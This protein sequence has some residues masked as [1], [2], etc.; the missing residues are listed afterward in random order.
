MKDDQ[1][2]VSRVLGGDMKAFQ[3]LMRENQRLVT[4]MVSRLVKQ[5]GEVEELCQDIFLK[6]YDKLGEFRFQSKL[7]TWIGTIAYREAINHLR[8]NKIK[9]ADLPNDD[10]LLKKL[11]TEINPEEIL[12]EADEEAFVIRM[13]QRLPPQYQLVLT[14][15]HLENKSYDEIGVITGM[16]EGT[17]K[18]YLFRA[19]KQLKDLLEKVSDK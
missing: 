18:N 10:S 16:P 12:V 8:K 2:L 4:N 1:V 19:R 3:L 6:V 7:S 14:L 9:W 11:A 15:Y 5:T 17:V 13:V